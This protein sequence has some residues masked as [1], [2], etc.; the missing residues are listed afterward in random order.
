[1]KKPK[2]STVTVL[3]TFFTGL[4]LLLF[5]VGYEYFLKE[6]FYRWLASLGTLLMAMGT[7]FSILQEKSSAERK[8]ED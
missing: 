4:V 2:I 1:M 7:F 8:V 6:P 5:S 3:F